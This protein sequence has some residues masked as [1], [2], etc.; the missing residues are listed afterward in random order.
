MTR[1]AHSVPQILATAVVQAAC[2]V[3]TLHIGRVLQHLCTVTCILSISGGGQ[4][5]CILAASRKVR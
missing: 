1:R 5:T 4:L 2:K 3:L